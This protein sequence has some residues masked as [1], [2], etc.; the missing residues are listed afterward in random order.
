[1]SRA[2]KDSGIPWIGEIPSH[3]KIK[4]LKYSCDLFGRIGFRGYT[5]DDLVGKG[6]GAITLSPTNMDDIHLDLSHCS[7]L[8]WAKYYES[9]EIMVNNGDVLLVKTA[10]VGKCVFVEDLPMEA[11]VNPQILVLKN[12]HD[13]AKYLAYIFQTPEGQCYIDTTKGGSTI[14]TISQDKIGNYA[15]AFPPIQEQE[16]IVAFLDRKCREIDNM[17]SLHE[18]M[19]VELKEY[20]QSVITEVVTKGL[21]PDVSSKDSGI[22]WIGLIPDGWRL[23]RVKDVLEDGKDGIKIGPF[24]SALTNKIEDGGQYKI[25]GQWN[26]VGRDF[27]EG[28]NYI[29]KQTYD[30]LQSYCIFSG[31]VLVS[32]MG[33][34]G[35]CA[36]IPEGIQKGII[37]S[38]VIKIRLNDRIMPS[39]FE[40]IYDKDNS[41]FVFE[42]IQRMKKGSIMDGL[43]SSIVKNLFLLLPPRKEQQDIVNYLD[44]KC[45]QIDTLISLKQSKIDA[46]KEYK[47]SIIYEYV[48]GKKEVNG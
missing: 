10:S 14:F 21:N 7:Y 19:I 28:K 8:S 1:M 40:Y 26:I 42:Q 48:T 3:W 39:F 15:F 36:V 32:L 35:K 29:S 27:S 4:R 38:H 2:M 17:V 24:G 43:N 25:Y 12:H 22:K 44:A 23:C 46:L 9:P 45:S 13:N 31:D 6:E 16:E 37:D 30:E 33:T 41:W 11:T 47:K 34:V 20:R 18:N 5:A